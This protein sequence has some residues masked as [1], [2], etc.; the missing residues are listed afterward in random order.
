MAE[1]KQMAPDYIFESGW[2]VC[3]KVGGIYTVLSTRANTLQTLFPDKII[4]IGPDLWK[5]SNNPDFIENNTLLKGWKKFARE[6]ENLSVRV[7]RWNIPGKPIVIL[8]D[9]QSYYEIKNSLY[10]EMW[11]D[12]GVDSI[13]AYGD[14][15]ESCVF[16]YA[17]G[18][19]IESFYRFYKLENIRVIALFNEWMLGMGALYL[20]SKVPA[21]STIFTTHATSV[22]RAIA[23]NDKPLYDQ[24]PNYNGDQMATELHVEGKHLIAI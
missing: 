2:E 18:K 9:F 22:G 17:V 21:I 11:K 3:N 7:G 16:A 1:K 10:F 19:V 20:R 13:A 14:Y 4:F 8:I 6:K 5:E 15:D 23:G 12:F 24:M